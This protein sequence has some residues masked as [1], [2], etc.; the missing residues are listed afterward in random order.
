MNG[1]GNARGIATMQS[2]LANGGANGVQLMSD[3]GRQ[4][5]LEQQSDGV[6]LVIGV[7]CRWGMGFSL[8]MLLFPGV[9]SGARAAWWAGNGGSLSFIDLDARM[10]IGYVPNR[11]ISG[12]FEQVR[13]GSVVRAAYQ[14]LG[15]RSS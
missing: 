13:S 10:A 15:T 3:A 2:L 9:P 5:V 6:D 11:W 14:A 1:H 8:E 7:P 12:P 4:R